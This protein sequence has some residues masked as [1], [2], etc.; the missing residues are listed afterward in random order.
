M[1][2]SP[3]LTIIQTSRM[4]ISTH[5]IAESVIAV[6]EKYAIMESTNLPKRLRTLF[7]NPEVRRYQA[8]GTN[9]IGKVPQVIYP[10]EHCEY[11][12]VNVAKIEGTIRNSP[13]LLAPLQISS[14]DGSL[15]QPLAR[16]CLFSL[17]RPPLTLF[18]SC[19][20]PP[21]LEATVV[22]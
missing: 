20:T 6:G 15:L 11:S 9:R 3:A 12:C 16:S 17:L 5:L 19:L 4:I 18:P 22:C 8:E 2:S 21:M 14:K 7:K 10:K 1:P 13:Y